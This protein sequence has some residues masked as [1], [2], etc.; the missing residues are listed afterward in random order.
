[1]N[2]AS[3]V[4][5]AMPKGAMLGPISAVAIAADTILEA[6]MKEFHSANLF[7]GNAWIR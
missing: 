4:K 6:R 1:M 5:R 7:H 3:D 2:D